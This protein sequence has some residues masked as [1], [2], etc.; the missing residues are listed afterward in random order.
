M[1]KTVTHTLLAIGF[2]GLTSLAQAGDQKAFAGPDSVQYAKDLWMA[3]EQNRLVGKEMI[4]GSPYDG[5]EPHGAILETM[6]ATV[7][8]NGY[9]GRAIVKRNYGPSGVDMDAVKDNRAK[10]LGAVTV[11]FKREK[12]YDT[13]HKN[14]FWAK[15]KPNG[16]LHLNPAGMKLAGRIAKGSDKGCIACHKGA[17]DDMIFTRD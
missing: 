13:D 17:G 12:G 6:D 2:I 14:W 5:M 9:T 16:S 1:K 11:M 8:I 15:F 7:T 4:N 10:Y 3:L